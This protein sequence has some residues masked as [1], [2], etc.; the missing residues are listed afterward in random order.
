MGYNLIRYVEIDIGGQVIDRMY[1]EFMVL[2]SQLTNPVDARL[3]LQDMLS[4]PC[5]T[6]N[7]PSKLTYGSNCAADG[8][9]HGQGEDH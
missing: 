4:G 5:V 9:A 2:W 6:A 7:G 8:R 1:S 3:K